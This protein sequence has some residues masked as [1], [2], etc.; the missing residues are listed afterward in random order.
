MAFRRPYLK[1]H[2]LH[3][4]R[5]DS[6]R[7]QQYIVTIISG[8]VVVVVQLVLL[9]SILFADFV[10]DAENV[11]GLVALEEDCVD[12]P[13]RS[14]RQIVGSLVRYQVQLEVGAEA[15]RLK[16]LDRHVLLASTSLSR[17]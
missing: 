16:L 15:L 7:R 17:G 4:R 2:F 6:E 10:F 5:V 1:L 11:H 14:N 13:L 3:V 8:G 9:H 12:R